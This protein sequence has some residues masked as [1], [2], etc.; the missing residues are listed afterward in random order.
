MVNQGMATDES[1][2]GSAARRNTWRHVS[3]EMRRSLAQTVKWFRAAQHIPANTVLDRRAILSGVQLRVGQ[4][5]RIEDFVRL[6]SGGPS[7]ENE[8]IVIGDD[9]SIRSHAQIYTMGGAVTIGN[10][11]SVNPFCVL[12]G[13]GGLRI[14][15]MVRIASHTV[16]VPSMHRFDRIDIPICEQGS[17]SH[18]IEIGD[19]VWIGAGVRILDNVR[20]GNGAIVAAGA[21]VVK[22]IPPY[23]IVGGVP[24]RLIRMRTSRIPDAGSVEQADR[25]QS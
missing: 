5:T 11:C 9:C 21:V 3:R 1:L 23:S 12:Y 15:N 18:G 13:T 8:T 16:I 25:G 20:I 14:G 2:R 6:Q 24:A 17:D 7:S 19:D 4:R 10:R 22:D